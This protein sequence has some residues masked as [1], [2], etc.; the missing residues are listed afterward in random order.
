MQIY[1]RRHH[2]F[3]VGDYVMVQIRP[4]RYPPGIVKKLLAR[5]AGPFKILKKINSNAYEVDLLSD[6]SIIP[7][8][9]IEDR[10]AYKG[11]IFPLIIVY[12]MSL[13]M[14]QFLRDPYYLFF[15]KYIPPIWQNKLMKLL[16]IKLSLLE[17]VVT[18][19]FWFV[20]KDYLI[21]TTLRLIGKSFNS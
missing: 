13:P 18:T 14:S 9:N 20:G 4:E 1:I 2:K 21:L 10:I 12:W 8:F 15:P 16:M 19:D 3:N 6:F 17:M 5:S 7:S 11:Q